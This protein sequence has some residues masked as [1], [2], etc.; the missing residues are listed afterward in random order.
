[1]SNPNDPAGYPTRDSSRE[2]LARELRALQ[3]DRPIV[4]EVR[5]VE[6]ADPVHE[7][8][9]YGGGYEPYVPHDPS[10]LRLEAP[11]DGGEPRATS[12]AL[13]TR[14]RPEDARGARRTTVATRPAEGLVPVP[15]SDPATSPLFP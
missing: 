6:P 14:A 1:M 7:A 5:N 13:A 9:G 15:L 4:P 12:Q 2:Q 8:D 11:G 10:E 3:D